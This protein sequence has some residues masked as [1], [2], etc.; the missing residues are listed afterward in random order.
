MGAVVSLRRDQ[1]PIRARSRALCSSELLITIDRDNYLM[2]V[3]E[4]TCGRIQC[5]LP[6]FPR[7]IPDLIKTHRRKKKTHPS[8]TQLHYARNSNKLYAYVHK[9]IFKNNVS[10]MWQYN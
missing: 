6:L 9:G 7:V 4:C 5:T 3:R 2:S 8:K 10:G 1:L